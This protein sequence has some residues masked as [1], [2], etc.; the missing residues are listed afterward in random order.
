MNL[1]KKL[2]DLVVSALPQRITRPSK[3]EMHWQVYHTDRLSNAGPGSH[4]YDLSGMPN[5]ITGKSLNIGAWVGMWP[6]IRADGTVI[7]G[8][9][10]A[11]ADIEETKKHFVENARFWCPDENYDGWL[12]LDHENWWPQ[13][14]RTPQVY[15]DA[16]IRE[17]RSSGNEAY[18]AA[19]W[20]RGATWHLLDVIAIVRKLRPK[21]KIAYYGLMIREYWDRYGTAA[22]RE[23]QVL[24]DQVLA[25]HRASDAVLCNLYQFYPNAAG[26]REYVRTNILEAKRLARLAGGK[27][28]LAH[29][30]YRY[31]DSSASRFQF[32]SQHD[33]E[34]Q[35][36]YARELGINGVFIWGDERSRS[37]AEMQVYISC[38]LG[39]VVKGVR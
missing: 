6:E 14:E 24:N 25:I 18:Y 1:I 11:L 17:L 33:L 32:C 8:G 4:Q 15:R 10:P 35:I 31:H 27:P 12:V 3:F 21:A 30:W 36:Q 20:L 29:T 19:S 34:V 26:N 22:G 16:I 2:G 39:P 38:I 9:I 7:N 37:D 5:I 23:N 28:V 13:W